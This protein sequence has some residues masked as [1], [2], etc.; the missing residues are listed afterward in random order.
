VE[1]SVDELRECRP[2][3]ESAEEFYELTTKSPLL[4]IAKYFN[5][6]RI[7]AAIFRSPALQP[8]GPVVVSA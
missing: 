7:N 3:A 5:T 8:V 1:N 4:K 2:S 6:L